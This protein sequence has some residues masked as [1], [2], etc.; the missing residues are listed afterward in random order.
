MKQICKKYAKICYPY[1]IHMLNI[2]SNMQEYDK[3]MHKYAIVKYAQICTNMQKICKKYAQICNNMQG[4]GTLQNRQKYANY[5]HKYAQICIICNQ[6]F[7]MQNMHEYAL[8]TLL[9]M[10]RARAPAAEGGKAR[11]R[12]ACHTRPR[13]S[14]GGPPPARFWH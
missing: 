12:P 14:P 9:M 10:G 7:H 4:L 1:A 2:C 6:G 11:R 8:P 3:N 5:M 13:G